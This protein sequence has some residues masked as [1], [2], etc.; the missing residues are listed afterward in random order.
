MSLVGEAVDILAAAGLGTPGTNLFER[1]LPDSPDQAIGVVPYQG[2]API[3]QH[4]SPSPQL[5]QPRFQVRCRATDAETA[6]ALAWQVFRVLTA[7]HD[8]II[9]PG[10]DWLAVRPLFEPF[11]LAPDQQRREV[12]VCSYEILRRV[13]P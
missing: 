2:R 6:D 1:T 8:R 10:I 5:F 9:V 11:P 3:G 4:D 13:A 12:T 7:V